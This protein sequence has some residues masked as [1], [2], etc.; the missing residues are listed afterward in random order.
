MALERADPPNPTRGRAG[1]GL[2]FAQE[3]L[4]KND[5]NKWYRHPEKVS[6]SAVGKKAEAFAE[7]NGMELRVIL[8]NGVH[9]LYGIVHRPDQA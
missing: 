7:A 9:R 8:V 4:A 1:V 3:L 6:R 5:P 2:L